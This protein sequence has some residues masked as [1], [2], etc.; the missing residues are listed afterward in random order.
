MKYFIGL[1][2][3]LVQI[4]SGWS[5][6]TSTENEKNKPLRVGVVGLVHGHVDWIL[7]NKKKSNIQIVGIV[8][9][10]RD[11]AKRLTKQYGYSM[12]IVYDSL[13]EMVEAKNPEAVNAFNSTY[14][15]LETV[16]YCAPKGIHVMVEKPLAVS[17]EHA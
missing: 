3:V 4:T 2:L 5:Q 9:P 16:R 14:G 17:W 6:R 1:V 7:A 15:H 12:D 10:N 11:L 13:E 8:E